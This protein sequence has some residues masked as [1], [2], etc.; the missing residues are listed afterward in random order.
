MSVTPDTGLAVTPAGAEETH[1]DPSAPL[2]LIVDDVQENLEISGYLLQRAGYRVRVASSGRRGLELAKRDPQPDLILLDIMMPEMDGFAVL[3]ALRADT[4]TAGIPVIFLTALDDPK[5]QETGLVAG[6]VDYISKPI[7]RGIL[8]ARIRTQLDLKEARD[9]L[10]RQRASLQAEVNRQVAESRLLESQLQIALDSSGFTIWRYH[11]HNGEYSFSDNISHLLGYPWQSLPA[12]D[13]LALVHP[14]DLHHAQRAIDPQATVSDTLLVADY[15]MRHLNGTWTWVEARSKTINRNSPENGLTTLGT[16]SDISGRKAQEAALEANLAAQRQLNKRLEEAHNQLLQSEKMASIGQLAAGVAHELN[17]PIGFVHSN[18]GTLET[19]LRDLMEIIKAYE[20]AASSAGDSVPKLAEA[21]QLSK[22]RELEYIEADIFDLLAESKDGLNRLR[23][24]VQDL[25]SFSRVGEQ[26]WQEADLHQGLDSTL[27]IVWNELKYKCTV[28][29]VYGDIPP[30]HCLISQLNQ[31]FMNL[32]VNA[33]HAI[34]KRGEITIRTCPD[35]DH[36][37]I[38]IEDSG[39]G[40][41]PGAS[42]PHLRALF[43]HQA[44]RQGHRARAVG[45]L[46]HHS[47]P[48]R[49]HRGAQR[50]DKGTC[51]RITL[52]VHPAAI[53]ET[54]STP[55]SNTEGQP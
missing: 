38:E 36:I 46:Q 54:A 18:L 34:E 5:S 14:D 52:P 31:V 37:C 32:L 55:G 21:Q 47:A 11:H 42:Q 39:K 22:D 26:D 23:K 7:L 41:P 12:A 6:A 48:P 45:V 16:L 40:I 1:P 8:L 43:H 15:R 35:A 25:K 28:N 19:Y 13:Y 49:A 44:S 33:G 27:N 53:H 24:I 50:V 30:V 9:Q 10:L 17:N 51:F 3:E 4:T 20:D 29:K 2:I